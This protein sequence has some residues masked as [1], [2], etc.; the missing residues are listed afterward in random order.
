[1]SYQHKLKAILEKKEMKSNERVGEVVGPG[2]VG[3]EDLNFSSNPL[4]STT[5]AERKFGDNSHTIDA[6]EEYSDES[7]RTSNSHHPKKEVSCFLF[8]ELF[9]LYQF[10]D[11]YVPVGQYEFPFTF[12]LPPTIPSSFSLK[13][14]NGQDY[15]IVYTVKGYLGAEGSLLECKKEIRVLN[16]ARVLER[17]YLESEGCKDPKEQK[18]LEQF[19]KDPEYQVYNIRLEQ[20]KVIN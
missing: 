2:V 7:P 11:S 4:D 20:T 17:E 18:F 9:S 8:S 15:S 13:Q 10:C 5:F 14:A 3:G 16:R 6:P 12:I 19:R 1:M